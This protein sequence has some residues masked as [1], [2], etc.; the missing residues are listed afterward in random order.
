MARGKP[1]VRNIF[2]ALLSCGLLQTAAAQTREQVMI[3]AADGRTLTGV[4]FVPERGTPAPAVIVLHTAYGS[5]ERFDE[6]F[7]RALAKEGF[8]ALAPNYIHSS[9]GNRLWSPSITA[10]TTALVDFLRQRPESRDMPVGTVGFSLGSR[11]LLLAARRPEVKAVVVYYGTFD[12]RKE[13]GIKLAPGIPVPMDVAAQVSAPVL[14][15]HGD[16]DDEI[17]VSSA[18][19]M[20]SALDANG[21]KA[22]LVEYKG[23]YHRFD[24]GPSDRMRTEVSRE[25]HT[26]RKDDAAAADAYART[27]AW[28]KA[29]LR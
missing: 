2:A 7:A 1:V 10:D 20:K 21:K 23:A 6:E 18:R 25:G 13:K 11:G 17:P 24:R 26:Y 19:A 22:E 12:V 16:A 8:V 3:P 15:L 29:H 27:V 9:V 28:L 4:L 14:L 5:V